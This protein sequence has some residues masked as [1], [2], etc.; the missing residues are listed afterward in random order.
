VSF[1]I[2]HEEGAVPMIQSA[3][4]PAVR[5]FLF[6]PERLD[7][8]YLRLAI[9][10]SSLRGDLQVLD[11]NAHGLRL[12]SALVRTHTDLPQ[13][14]LFQYD[15]KR[16]PSVDMLRRLRASE[17][18]RAL[19][20]V[21]LGDGEN[22]ESEPLAYQDGADA[23]IPLPTRASELAN[24]GRDIERFWRDRSGQLADSSPRSMLPQADQE[25]AS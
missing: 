21:V 3:E 19:P 14:V 24:T 9:S 12:A 23:F 2:R 17:E 15:R 18:L 5:V 7:M 13:L 11:Q 22:P 8:F 20:L 4:T 6:K 1:K 16:S 10:M 25:R